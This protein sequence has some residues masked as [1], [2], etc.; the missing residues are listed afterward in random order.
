[1]NAVQGMVND[2]EQRIYSGL[3]Y[4]SANIQQTLQALSDPANI[5]AY[6]VAPRPAVD[7][8]GIGTPDNP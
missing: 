3:Q 4:I 8:Q 7:R 6:F 1:M 5:T 2:L